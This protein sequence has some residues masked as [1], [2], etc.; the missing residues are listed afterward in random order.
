MSPD[1]VLKE[2]ESVASE[3]FDNKYDIK[4][5]SDPIWKQISDSLDKKISASSLYIN[6]YQD[7]HSWQTVLRQKCSYP[8]V[9]V[10]NTVDEYDAS[11]TSSKTDDE[12]DRSSDGKCQD[13]GAEATGWAEEKPEEGMPLTLNIILLGVK[14]SVPHQSKRPL[15]G[16][17]RMEVGLE[18]VHDCASNWKRNITK[19]LKFGDKIPACVQ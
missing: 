10:P 12:S 13:C 16:T 18:L 15:N 11:I 5:Y 6:V 17:K 7:R 4:G 9:T 3:L 19:S 14:K 8:L 2:L 1:L